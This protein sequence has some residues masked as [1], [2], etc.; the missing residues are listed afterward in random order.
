MLNVLYSVSSLRTYP[1][2]SGAAITSFAWMI[3]ARLSTTW[4]SMCAPSPIS[5]PGRI[6]LFFTTAPFLITQRV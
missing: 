3:F 2:F 6:T 1:G 5:A 4:F